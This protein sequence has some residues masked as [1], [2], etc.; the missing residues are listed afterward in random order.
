MEKKADPPPRA[1][2]LVAGRRM[3]NAARDNILLLLF[4]FIS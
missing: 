4:D 1:M 2:A 3:V